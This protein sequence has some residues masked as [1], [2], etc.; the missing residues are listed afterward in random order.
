VPLR[1][2]IETRLQ[3]LRTSNLDAIVLA[4]AGLERLGIIPRSYEILSPDVMVPAFNQGLIGLEC[5]ID[6]QALINQLYHCSDP[7][8]WQRYKWERA[9]AQIF[10]ASCHSAIGIYVIPTDNGGADVSVF[11]A[12]SIEQKRFLKQ[13]YLTLEEALKHIPEFFDLKTQSWALCRF[14]FS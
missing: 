4:A 14:E 8:D 9:I 6:N 10:H 13:Y 11:A 5:R 12:R 3:Q 7:L 2:N 1:G